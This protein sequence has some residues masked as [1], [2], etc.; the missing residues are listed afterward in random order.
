MR[1]IGNLPLLYESRFDFHIIYAI[2]LHIDEQQAIFKH[3]LKRHSDY[4]P[5]LEICNKI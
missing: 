2:F 3:T 5:Y 1:I 4:F